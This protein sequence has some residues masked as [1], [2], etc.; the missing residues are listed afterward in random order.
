MQG[1]SQLA[2][3]EGALPVLASMPGCA[4]E[5]SQAQTTNA[6]PKTLLTRPSDVRGSAT[7][8]ESP[9]ELSTARGGRSHVRRLVIR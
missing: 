1:R 5:E 7:F 6:G 3:A 8:D 9:A 4:V 2:K